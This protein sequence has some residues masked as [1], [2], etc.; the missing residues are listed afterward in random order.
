MAFNDGAR[1]CPEDPLLARA[2]RGVQIPG[3]HGGARAGPVDGAQTA[4]RGELMAA[5]AACELARQ[6]LILATDN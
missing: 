3:G 2:A 1:N 4:Q 5:V 6:P